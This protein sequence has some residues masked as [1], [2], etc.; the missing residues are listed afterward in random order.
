MTG[1]PAA[2]LAVSDVE[3]SYEQSW[4]PFAPGGLSLRYAVTNDGNTRAAADT[5]VT[6]STPLADTE[7]TDPGTARSREVLPGG[8]RRFDSR[9]DAWPF[10]RVTTTITVTPGR[11]DGAPPCPRPPR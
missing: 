9:T 8:A 7:W 11:L 1:E 4:N 10:G 3:A 5:R 6:N 2:R